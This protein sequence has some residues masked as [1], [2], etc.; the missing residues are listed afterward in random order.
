LQVPPLLSVNE[1]SL[2]DDVELKQ[3][4]ILQCPYNFAC[5]KTFSQELVYEHI[6]QPVRGVQSIPRLIFSPLSSPSSTPPRSQ[7]GLCEI[8]FTRKLTKPENDFLSSRK[9]FQ[10]RK[11][12]EGDRA[13]GT[14]RLHNQGYV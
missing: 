6:Q 5:E 1:K 4:E 3:L 7:N 11:G 8:F 2:D 14:S 9:N 12:H 13:I 10:N